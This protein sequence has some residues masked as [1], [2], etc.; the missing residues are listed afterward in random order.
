MGKL[1][2]RIALILSIL[3]AVAGILNAAYTYR[4]K[5][6]PVAER[7]GLGQPIKNLLDTPKEPEPVPEKAFKAGKFAESARAYEEAIE[8]H[9]DD[10]ESHFG[11]AQSYYE[12]HQY[13]A[14]AEQLRAAIRLAP[15]EPK[16]HYWLAMVA[17]E[18]DA[19]EE[20]KAELRKTLEIDPQHVDARQLLSILGQPDEKLAAPEVG[21]GVHEER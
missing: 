12:L 2:T 8:T 9:P 16:Y 4:S 3:A 11:L 1:I 15:K 7:F 14:A 17:N 19:V 5:L 13:L 10:P 6:L 20:A 21:P 18:M